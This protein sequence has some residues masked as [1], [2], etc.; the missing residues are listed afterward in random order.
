MRPHVSAM[1]V[2][3]A[4]QKLGPGASEK[5]PLIAMSRRTQTTPVIE[6]INAL[7]SSAPDC[8]QSS[9]SSGIGSF[10]SQPKT[11]FSCFN[12][13]PTGV[14]ICH[15]S[16]SFN[17]AIRLEFDQESLGHR[18]NV[19]VT[20]HAKMWIRAVVQTQN[21]EL[22]S[23]LAGSNL[24]IA[25]LYFQM[26]KVASHSITELCNVTSIQSRS[27]AVVEVEVKAYSAVGDVVRVWQGTVFPNRGARCDIEGFY[28]HGCRGE[29]VC[30]EPD[31]PCSHIQMHDDFVESGLLSRRSEYGKS[32]N[33]VC[34]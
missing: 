30:Q 10:Y 4:S 2:V 22:D 28:C 33:N 18:N 27:R 24:L 21:S 29:R 7:G 19:A 1:W 11:D 14:L 3:H 5:L 23:F 9:C 8:I 32:V 26:A 20:H 17:E 6:T 34:N 15:D 31:K 12:F 16:R 25:S 13:E